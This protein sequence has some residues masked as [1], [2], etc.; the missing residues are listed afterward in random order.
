VPRGADGAGHRTACHFPV[1]PGDDLA[2]LRPT[3]DQPDRETLGE[4]PRVAGSTR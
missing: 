1:E 2:H 4:A 3:I